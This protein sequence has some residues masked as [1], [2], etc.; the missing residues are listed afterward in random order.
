MIDFTPHEYQELGIAHALEHP[1]CALWYPMGAGKTVT[2]LSALEILLLA[3]SKFF[4]WLVIAPPRVAIGVW[5]RENLKWAH[6]QG[7]KVVAISS[8]NTTPAKRRAALKQRADV[9]TINYE[10]IPW[11][12]ETLGNQ[13]PFRGVISDESTRLKGFRLRKGTKRARS[14]AKVAHKVG[15]W[16]NLSGTPAPAGL[17]DL[18][19]Q[20]WFLDEGARLGRTFTAF[21]ERWFRVNEYTRER[22]PLP[23]AEEEIHER[24][25]DI[26]MSIDLGDYLDVLEPFPVSVEVDLPAKAMRRYK[27]M[28]NEL[29]TVLKSGN[30]L[31]AFNGAA[32]S[33]KCLQMASGAVY[34]DEQKNWEIVH[35][36]KLDG[37]ESVI[38]EC[39]GNPLLVSYWWKH[40]KARLEKRFPYA[41][42]IKTQ[43]DEDDWNEG[44]ILVGLVHPASIGHGANLQY[45][46]HH[47]ATFSEWWDV[48]LNDQIFE[49]I[50]PVRQLQAGFDRTVFKYS[51]VARGT[52]DELVQVRN[53][54]KRSVQ[55][56][57]MEAAKR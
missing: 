12:V 55:A 38:E 24:V 20:T 15:R 30:E 51:I 40:D 3:G 33:A 50:G 14:L 28:E 49:R 43:K 45:G 26:C 44:K 9:Y 48:E 39:A 13:W 11:L 47:F 6:L 22:T 27:E 1:K 57:L 18:W 37:L 7:L 46:G 21:M 29:F 56:L 25:R 4:P 8:E 34:Y 35:D 19:G 16:I 23:F 17:I 54:S 31:E 5:T 53:T 41:R 2:V 10:N 32:K 42:E 36:A 52:I